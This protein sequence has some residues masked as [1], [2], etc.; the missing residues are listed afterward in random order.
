MRSLGSLSDR[1]L[2]QYAFSN[3]NGQNGTAA[4]FGSSVLDNTVYDN[5]GIRSGFGLDL[6]VQVTYRGNTLQS[7][8]SGGVSSGVN[9][10]DNFCEGPN[11]TSAAVFP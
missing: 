11:V 4:I 7:N 5:G 1:R 6:S 2:R 9:L 8:T 3:R 10:G